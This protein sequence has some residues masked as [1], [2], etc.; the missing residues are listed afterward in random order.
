MF[1]GSCMQDNTLVRTLRM[2]GADAVLIPTYTPIRVD[3]VSVSTER[4][5]LGGVNVYLDSIVPGWNRLPSFLTSWLN[6]PGLIRVLSRVNSSTDAA[7]LGQL[8]LDLLS[9]SKGPQHR[10]IDELVSFL[11]D[12]LQPD[13]IL[14]SNA[15]LSGI[16]PALRRR[17]AGPIL[18]ILQGDD[19][20]LDALKP[21]YRAACLEQVSGNCRHFDGVLTH[22]RYYSEF[23]ER[24]LAIPREKF[25]QI[26]LTIDESPGELVQERRSSGFNIGYFARICPEKGVQHLI[27]AAA[28]VL[29]QCPGTRVLIGGYLPDQHRSWF[30]K[31]LT[32]AQQKVGSGRIEWLGSPET[33][34]EKFRI[35]QSFDLLCVPT[36]YHEPKGLY[37]LE[38]AL[39]GVPSLVPNHGAFPERIQE[40]GHGGIYATTDSGNLTQAL[41]QIVRDRLRSAGADPGEPSTDRRELQ[42][43]VIELHGMSA[44]AGHLVTLLTSFLPASGLP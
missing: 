30:L 33:R 24:Y 37:V 17:F 20:F 16:V 25:R 21:R 36:E 40:L 41:L 23:M 6:R 18:T 31:R 1:C 29:P 13:L 2:G 5:F 27:D 3:E 14:F 8:T 34:V 15:L 7:K 39:C 19:I 32:A 11:C 10:E 12:E 4:V 44:T 43:K 9:G 35:L 22:S 42:Q 26:P 38:A 28:D